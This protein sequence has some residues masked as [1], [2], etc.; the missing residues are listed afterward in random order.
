MTTA[1]GA[2]PDHF[3]ATPTKGSAAAPFVP[4]FSEVA[5]RLI[6][7]GYHPLPILAGE[8]RPAPASWQ[9]VCHRPPSPRT[10][11]QWGRR[12]PNA[13]TGAACGL[14][15]AIDIDRLDDAAAKDA[16]RQARSMLGDTP[17]LRIGRAPKRVLLYRA[18]GAPFTSLKAGD[19]EVL[20]LGR[21]VVLFH[22]HPDT[23]QP[24]AWPDESPLDV[25]V[26]ALPAVTEIQA[27]RWLDAVT[28]VGSTGK[29]LIA[30][31]GNRH[32][33]LFPLVRRAAMA[34]SSLEDLTAEAH[35]LN[36]AVCIPPLP[37]SQVLATAHGVWRYREQG[38]L[39]TDDGESRALVSASEFAVLADEPDA[40]AL[41]LLL[42]LSHGTREEPFMLLAEN[43][44]EAKLIGDFGEKRYA[45]LRD[46][47]VDRGFV[48]L[49]HRGHGRGNASLYR[50]ALWTTK[51]PLTADIYKRNSPHPLQIPERRT[52]VQVQL[53]TTATETAPLLFAP[54]DL[55][56]LLTPAEA[57]RQQVRGWCREGGRGSQSRLSE[58]LGLSRHTVANWL[59]GRYPLNDTAEAT[60]RRIV[61]G[62]S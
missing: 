50:L 40:L 32:D 58:T 41:L 62:E 3:D 23:G 46:V 45:R 2:V 38:T 28:G 4:P 17:L 43:M 12:W 39:W 51:P 36:T 16:E 27:R 22:L 26:S 24:Y 37:D 1:K 9:H 34:A 7:N 13:G 15:V 52:L 5:P 25:P 30:M 48:Q 42:R 47:L 10:V 61:G 18:A 8:K 21:Q 53:C 14:I 35:R 60:L 31:P 11:E 20:A 59:A 56:H 44:A 49:I 54:S 55:P 6:D 19:C 57:L 29:G 33:V